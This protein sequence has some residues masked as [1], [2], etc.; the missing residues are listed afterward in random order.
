MRGLRSEGECRARALPE[1]PGRADERRTGGEP[2]PVGPHREDRRRRARR[3]GRCGGGRSLAKPQAPPTATR[4]PA[5]AGPSAPAAAR[6]SA[7]VVKDPAQAPQPPPFELAS[8]LTPR[9][10]ERRRCRGA[11]DVSK[12]PS[13][14]RSP[15]CRRS[16]TTSGRVLL[17]LGRP[18]EAVAP[19]KQALRAEGGQL[20]VHVQHG[21]RVRP[22]GA[23]LG[24]GGRLP[25]ARAC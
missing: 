1:M 8:G 4:R 9:P 12:P 3:C 22:L 21:L 18:R 20:V 16:S 5:P 15:G 23:V 13:N 25:H 7:A 6:R 19:L 17:R 2:Q 10:G 14:T 11:R 24:G